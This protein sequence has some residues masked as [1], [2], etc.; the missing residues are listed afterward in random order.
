MTSQPDQTAQRWAYTLP[1]ALAVRQSVSSEN[2]L[3]R[4]D[5]LSASIASAILHCAR[6]RGEAVS[7][8][9]ECRQR[10][11]DEGLSFSAA[12]RADPSRRFSPSSPVAEQADWDAAERFLRTVPEGHWITYQDLAAAA[13]RPKAAQSAANWLTREW[14]R[15]VSEGEE[16]PEGIH[17]I[18]SAGGE[19]KNSWMPD[20]HA[21]SPRTG[22]LLDASV[23]LEDPEVEPQGPEEALAQWTG[24]AEVRF[25]LL[26]DPQREWQEARRAMS[27]VFLQLTREPIEDPASS[28]VI[29]VS[30]LS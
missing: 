4:P 30:Q 10:L 26:I 17:R 27:A 5:E 24:R 1:L 11:Q 9:E 23:T 25:L 6:P 2:L 28:A 18:L 3:P 12:G 13:G 7:S 22:D 19:L 16:H 8:V 29:S 20:H 15:R 14:K 21:P